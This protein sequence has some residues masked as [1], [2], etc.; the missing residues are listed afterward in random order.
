[1]QMLLL[2]GI[3][4]AHCLFLYQKG[5]LTSHKISFRPSPVLYLCLRQEVHK[6]VT[7][8]LLQKVIRQVEKLVSHTS[9]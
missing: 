9:S 1:M 8:K 2:F 6:R 7:D 4:Q 5:R 3:K